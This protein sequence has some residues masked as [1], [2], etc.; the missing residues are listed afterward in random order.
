MFYFVLLYL[1]PSE[2]CLFSNERQKGSGFRWERRRG[3]TGRA[4][5][6]IIIKI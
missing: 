5:E 1:Y 6:E 2:A 4:K 3:G